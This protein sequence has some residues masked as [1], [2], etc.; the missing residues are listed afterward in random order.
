M[1]LFEEHLSRRVILGIEN[2]TKSFSVH[3]N[4]ISNICLF[5]LRSSCSHSSPTR[6][7]D[8]NET[9]WNH[10]N[11]ERLLHIPLWVYLNTTP[12]NQ[13]FPLSYKIYIK[14]PSPGE[15]L[16]WEFDSNFLIV[17]RKLQAATVFLQFAC[18]RFS[19]KVYA[20]YWSLTMICEA[21]QSTC[22]ENCV[23]D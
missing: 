10:G 15:N 19:T 21:R 9:A 13:R 11:F 12:L 20:K 22:V 14:L 17:L 18:L 7:K 8:S 4:D 16:Q 1:I 3:I 2:I 5:G 6:T 23:R